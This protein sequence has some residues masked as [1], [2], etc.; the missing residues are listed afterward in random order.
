MKDKSNNHVEKIGLVHHDE[1]EQFF[2]KINRLD[3]LNYGNLKCHSCHTTITFANFRA[4]F[5]HKGTLYFV[6]RNEECFR[7]AEP[8]LETEDVE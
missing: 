7:C 8:I 4:V 5:N 2:E 1:L 6:C 3:D